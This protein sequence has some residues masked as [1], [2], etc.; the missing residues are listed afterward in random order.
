MVS[1]W[2]YGQLLRTELV[3]KKK[4]MARLGLGRVHGQVWFPGRQ[5]PAGAIVLHSV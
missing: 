3:L 4:F 1:V 2:G 5:C